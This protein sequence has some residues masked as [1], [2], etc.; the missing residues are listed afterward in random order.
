MAFVVRNIGTVEQP[1]FAV[2][3]E[4]RKPLT[5]E[6]YSEIGL[7]YNHLLDHFERGWGIGRPKALYF[8]NQGL[9]W[10]DQSF[11][12]YGLA[13]PQI[14]RRATGVYVLRDE[15]QPFV[16]TGL[17]SVNRSDRQASVG[18]D[19]SL[20]LTSST[21]TSWNA[22]VRAGAGG[23]V[24][25]EVGGDAYGAKVGYTAS[26][27]V[28]AG[29]GQGGREEKSEAVGSTFSASVELPPHTGA[30]IKSVGSRG[31]L[32]L[33]VP[34]EVRVDG[35]CWIDYGRRV[36]RTPNARAAFF[37]FEPMANLLAPKNDRMQ[38]NVDLYANQSTYIDDV[39]CDCG[40]H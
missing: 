10:G 35:Y 36:A 31:I 34:F 20:T 14:I 7:D 29:Y 27:N 5:T 4:E 38:V 21:E 2:S 22:D 1:R 17:A 26:W 28:E 30:Q 13:E 3:G 37:H 6:D 23:S 9:P 19:T 15:T 33:E 8:S 11:G 32:I 12:K 18:L 16:A 25:V 39:A 40:E 24:S